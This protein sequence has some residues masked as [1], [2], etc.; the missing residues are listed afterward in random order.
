M[1]MKNHGLGFAI[2]C[3][4]LVLTLLSTIFVGATVLW[5]IITSYTYEQFF[6]VL[7]LILKNAGS[8]SV[9]LVGIVI[10]TFYQIYMKEVELEKEDRIKI[11]EVGYYTLAFRRPEDTY[12]ENFKEEKMVVEING[13]KDYVFADE[14]AATDFF[15]PFMI[16]FLTSKPNGTNLKNIMAFSDDFMKKNK[17]DILNNYFAYCE[18]ITYSS[19]L[20]CSAK[21]TS[22]L[23]SNCLADRNRYFWLIIKKQENEEIKNIWISAVTEEGI[24]LFVNAKVH[25]KELEEGCLIILLQQTTYYKSKNGLSPLYR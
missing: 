16:K 5:I 21:P 9:L 13:E 14:D 12:K 20:Y 17:K 11:E 8:Y 22:E 10:T 15:A 1:R 25:I 3:M 2:K 4:F 6:L 19:P 18:K 23:K 24:L 7:S